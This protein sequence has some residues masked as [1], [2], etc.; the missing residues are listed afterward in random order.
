MSLPIGV[1]ITGFTVDIVRKCDPTSRPFVDNAIYLCKTI[2]AAGDDKLVGDNKADVSTLWPA[3]ATTASYGGV[4][5][6]WGQTWI[7]GDVTTTV[8]GVLIQGM[9]QHAGSA[10]SIDAVQVTCHYSTPVGKG[11]GIVAH[12][13]PLVNGQLYHTSSD[14]FGGTANLQ[15][16]CIS[17]GSG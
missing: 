6:L 12:G 1:S 13:D 17:T 8:F 9:A 7:H 4:N 11:L 14:A 3:S 2:T 15:V 16:L 10:G 5:D